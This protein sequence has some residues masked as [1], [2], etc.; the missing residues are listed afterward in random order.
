MAAQSSDAELRQRVTKAGSVPELENLNNTNATTKAEPVVMLKDQ[1]S[2]KKWRNWWIRGMLS[3]LM[4]GLSGA[5][6]M[7]GPMALTLMIFI[8][9]LKCFHEIISIGHSTWPKELPLFRSLSWYFLLAANY[10]FYGENFTPLLHEFFAGST[11]QATAIIQYHRFVSF[12]L[13]VIGFVT[14]VLSLRAGFY[15]FQFKQFGWTHLALLLVVATS[16]LIVR[17]IYEGLIWFLL[18]S[19]MV[20]CNDIMAYLFGFFFGKTKLISLSPKKT[21]EGFIGAFWSTVVFAVFFSQLMASSP[22]LYCPVES[23]TLY[24][25]DNEDCLPPVAVL[26][27]TYTLMPRVQDILLLAGIERETFELQPIVIHA[28]VM[29]VFASLIAPFGGFFAS[30]LKRAFKIKDFDDLIPGHGGVTD[31]FDCQFVMAVFSFVYYHSF[32]KVYN[33]N[34]ILETIF[35]M[36][37]EAQIEVHQHLTA[38]LKAAGQLE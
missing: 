7:M 24:Q 21:W 18:P 2:A 32:I 25:I 9:Q 13:Y 20:V 22:F 11:T 12:W 5:V 19:S 10:F 16:Q 38:Y 35:A 1:P 28:V 15:K 31:R 34:G 37:P 8:L 33:V 6:V 27:Q 30:G 29:A 14:F 36:Q 26:P 3:L 4:I 23:L 17:S